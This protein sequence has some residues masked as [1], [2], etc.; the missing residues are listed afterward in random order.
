MNYITRFGIGVCYIAYAVAMFIKLPNT[1]LGVAAA[2]MGVHAALMSWYI[3]RLQ[4]H[5]SVMNAGFLALLQVCGDKNQE[6]RKIRDELNEEL[7]EINENNR[8][9]H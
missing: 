4:H 7:R 6:I 2:I 8:T 9:R 3:I 5:N 1:A